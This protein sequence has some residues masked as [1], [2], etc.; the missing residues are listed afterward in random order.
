MKHFS[1]IALILS[2]MLFP[3]TFKLLCQ[4]G[5][6]N[7]PFITLSYDLSDFTISSD[8]DGEVFV[9][10]S[11]FAVA[12][13]DIAN[14]PALPILAVN[15]CLP[16][17]VAF[18]ELSV[19]F[20]KSVIMQNVIMSHNTELMTTGNN[21]LNGVNSETD[22]T[23]VSEDNDVLKCVLTKS[24]GGYDVAF[25]TV[26]PFEY[27]EQTKE[28]SFISQIE[29]SAPLMSSLY[30]E[31]THIQANA[32]DIEVLKNLVVNP[33]YVKIETPESDL[34]NEKSTESASKLPIKPSVIEKRGYLLITSDSL[35]S[36]FSYL[37]NWKTRKGL[38][39]YVE[40]V[41]NIDKRYAEQ[42]I[43][44]KIKKCIYDYWMDKGVQYVLLGG[45]D[46]AIPA[47]K[48]HVAIM[49][50]DTI[51]EE[52]NIPSDLFYA[53]LDTNNFDWDL[54]KNGIAG[55]VSDSVNFVQDVYISRLPVRTKQDVRNAIG[56]IVSYE[57]N[58]LKNGWQNTMLMGGCKLKN[59]Y[60]MEQ[61]GRW[62]SDAEIIGTKMKDH[63]SKYITDSIVFFFDTYADFAGNTDFAFNAPNLQY[64]LSNHQYH[65]VDVNTHGTICGWATKTDIY[66]SEFAQTLNSTQFKLITTIACET[67]AFDSDENITGP[68]LSEAFIR[69]PQSGV[70]AYYG[71]SRSGWLSEYS[72]IFSGVMGPSHYCDEYF[73]ETLFSDNIQTKNYGK[74]VALAKNKTVAYCN[75]NMLYRWLHLGLN[76]IGDPETPIY[77]TTPLEFNGVSTKLEKGI[78]TISI[79]G[80]QGYNVT[81]FKE[82]GSFRR[83]LYNCPS[84]VVTGG[85]PYLYDYILAA[86]N[87]EFT[88][89]ITKQNYK[90]YYATVLLDIYI[91]NQT[92]ND[93]RYYMGN[94]IYIGED[95]ND[96][97]PTG[98]VIINSTIK[99]EAKKIVISD[100]TTFDA[101]S[102][103]L[104]NSK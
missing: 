82:D 96:S 103:V 24:I 98:P 92:I 68:C 45:D 53:C 3:T 70:I 40:T 43:Y 34:I 104:L 8:N 75:N 1:L 65:Y 58:P 84:T 29:L 78:L 41:E 80:M 71:C 35:K 54:N 66:N 23:D 83:T 91:Q 55:E 100:G 73:Y 19:S 28:L 39:T 52:D 79:P 18:N 72:G 16:H 56:K 44:L 88:I 38:S 94:D 46:D 4:N 64:V 21:Q 57:Q 47:K 50:A 25:L 30:N 32:S 42:N 26:L 85:L 17:G 11:K 89:C 86:N 6:N 102:D 74:I 36:S 49:Q 97:E 101:T 62:Q 63:M 5:Q 48:I 69:N 13:D 95:V 90:P 22:K 2:L 15:I 77:T 12:Y 14:K 93:N 10:S 60:D 27:N 20:K 7:E 31:N 81:I 67:N 59:R 61:T 99:L 33:E 9:T 37:I 76:A 51:A 87:N